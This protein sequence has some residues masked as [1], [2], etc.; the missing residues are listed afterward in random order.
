MQSDAEKLKGDAHIPAKEMFKRIYRYLN[1][2]W[3]SLSAR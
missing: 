1:P 2:K 3:V